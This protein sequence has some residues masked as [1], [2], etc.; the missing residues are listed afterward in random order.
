M[1]HKKPYSC[2]GGGKRANL[3]RARLSKG[4]SQQDVADKI[5]IS[6]ELYSQI[7]NGLRGGTT[8]GAPGKLEELFDLDQDYLM[9]IFEEEQIFIKNVKEK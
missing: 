3:I 2:R 8:K 5:G 9:Y 7:E 4:Y 1:A 6:R